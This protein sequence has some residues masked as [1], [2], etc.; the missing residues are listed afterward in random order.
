MKIELTKEEEKVLWRY[1]KH[2]WNIAKIS[3]HTREILNRIIME[4]N[5]ELDLIEKDL[6]RQNEI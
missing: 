4:C 1:R 6:N 3:E 2:L 5:E